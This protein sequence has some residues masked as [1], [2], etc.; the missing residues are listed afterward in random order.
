MGFPRQF[1][2]IMFSY[3]IKNKVRGNHRYPL[4]LVLEPSFFCN[5]K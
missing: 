1:S 3:L 4:A 5:L 2:T